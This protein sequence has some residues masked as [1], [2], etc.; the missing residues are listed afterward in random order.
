MNDVV[1][2][3]GN[4]VGGTSSGRSNRSN[5]YQRKTNVNRGLKKS[6]H[7]FHNIANGHTQEKQSS[8][9]SSRQP[10]KQ[11]V[12]PEKVIPLKGDDKTGTDD[13]KEFNG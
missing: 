7:T 2:E 10:A 1:G 6:D 3:L 9:P 5:K 12:A 8:Q 4:L 11:P 13:F